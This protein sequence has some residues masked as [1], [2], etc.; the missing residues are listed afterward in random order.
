MQRFGHGE[1]FR[2][3]VRAAEGNLNRFCPHPASLIE[4]VLEPHAAPHRI[5]DQV[6]ADVVA[7]AFQGV[8]TL[9]RR[10]RLDLVIGERHR[11]PDEARDLQPP[12]LRID[13][14]VEARWVLAHDVEVAGG[15]DFRREPLDA[16]EQR[17]R[18]CDRPLASRRK[19]VGQ[20]EAA[21]RPN[22]EHESTVEQVPACDPFAAHA[23]R[24][25][26]SRDSYATADE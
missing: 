2:V 10:Q 5:A 4:H 14:W 7:D 25:Q 13:D 23:R 9:H 3:S 24:L 21:Q 6:A 1:G 19:P 8:R 16:V 18:E 20:P 22:G 26:I 12:P 11:L 17:L 15:C